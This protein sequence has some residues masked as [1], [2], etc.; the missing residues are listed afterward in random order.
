M[1]MKAINSWA[2][3]FRSRSSLIYNKSTR[4]KRHEC[5]TSDTNATL[6]WHEWDKNDTSA[7][8]VQHECCTNNTS[9]T[10]VRHECYTNNTSTTRVLHERHKCDTSEQ[11][12]ILIT[13]QV[14]NNPILQ[15]TSERLQGEEQFHSKYYLW[16]CLIPMPKCVWKAHH[17]NWNF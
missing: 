12:L 5:D 11:I 8:Q 3:R 16:K 4:H 10:R 17:K 7:T 1:K 6:V 9:A 2:L 13:T 15:V 14:K